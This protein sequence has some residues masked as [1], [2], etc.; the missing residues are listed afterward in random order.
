MRGVHYRHDRLRHPGWTLT[1][2]AVLVSLGAMPKLSFMRGE[3]PGAITPDGCAVE[4]YARLR[5]RGEPELIHEAIGEKASVLELGAGAGRVTHPLR[6]LGHE[7]VAVDESPDM[8][9]RIRGAETVCAPIQDLNLGR[10]FDAVVMISFLIDIPD[11]D[12]M[13]AFLRTCRSHVRDDGCL[14]LERHKPGWHETVRPTERTDPAGFTSRIRTVERPEPGTVALT[15][16]YLWGDAS[17]THSFLTRPMSD[18]R[19][20]AELATAGFRIDRFLD[21]DRSWVRAR[22]VPGGQGA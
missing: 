14:I 8:L 12:L 21:P 7:I 6:D 11:D 18:E 4:F 19:L 13:R 15:V 3:G 9:A 10:R 17:W 22:P 16:D 20:S 2:V 5:A 1:L